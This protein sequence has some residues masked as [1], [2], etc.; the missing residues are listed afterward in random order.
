MTNGATISYADKRQ[1]DG[2]S[3][4]ARRCFWMVIA[5][6]TGALPVAVN[7]NHR[8]AETNAVTI[9]SVVKAAEFGGSRNGKAAKSGTRQ[10]HEVIAL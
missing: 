3:N 9:G 7:L 6:A 2:G 1:A 8:L 10:G 4:G 5:T